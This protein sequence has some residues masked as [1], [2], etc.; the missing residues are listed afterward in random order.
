M[1][2]WAVIAL[3]A[4]GAAR[5]GSGTC[6]ATHSAAIVVETD[7][8]TLWLCER[9]SAVEGYRVSIGTAGAGK[10]RE[11]D[12]KTPLGTYVLGRPRSSDRFKLFIPVDYPTTAERA[13][14]FTGSD[15]G[16]HGPTR[17]TAW[18]G[19]V[20]TWTDWTRGCIAVG[21]DDDIAAIGK[22]MARTTPAVI[23]IRR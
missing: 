14:G 9:G 1:L 23:V 6:P 13:R 16:I 20:N 17:R 7:R 15:I 11:G 5:A 10:E 18:M 12:S 19:H 22:W 8:H 4:C 3:T 21:A 2:R